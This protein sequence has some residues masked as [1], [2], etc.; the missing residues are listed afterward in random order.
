MEY[1][2]RTDRKGV[3]KFESVVEYSRTFEQLY[4]G[5]EVAR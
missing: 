3:S 5:L 1:S 4:D 2:R